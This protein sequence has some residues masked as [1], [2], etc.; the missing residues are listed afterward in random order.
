LA[1]TPPI[2]GL[3]SL[4]RDDQAWALWTGLCLSRSGSFLPASGWSAATLADRQPRDCWNA[5][6]ACCYSMR[7]GG[8]AG[9]SSGGPY[10]R[11]CA[12]F[13]LADC[14]YV[15]GCGARLA[16][17]VCRRGLVAC[18]DAYWATVGCSLWSLAGPEPRP[19]PSQT[20][21]ATLRAGRKPRSCRHRWRG[22][23]PHGRHPGRWRMVEDSQ[24]TLPVHD[25]DNKHYVPRSAIRGSTESPAPHQ[26]PCGSSNWKRGCRMR[27]WARPGPRPL[28]SPPLL[29][30]HQHLYGL[31]FGCCWPLATHAPSSQ[32]ASFWGNTPPGIA[33]AAGPCW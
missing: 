17:S 22:A 14:F 32:R 21:A 1:P 6:R 26:G 7:G 4:S 24:A 15:A 25:A 9:R 30:T 18:D 27:C 10:N 3:L 28:G 5:R 8:Q 13:F 2:A 29:L 23:A 19:F 31:T 33:E 11:F 20:P 12:S 16:A